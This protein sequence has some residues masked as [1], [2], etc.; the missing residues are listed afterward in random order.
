[1]AIKQ[2]IS[3]ENPLCGGN[4]YKDILNLATGIATRNIKQLVFTGQEDWTLASINSHGIANFRYP[5]TISDRLA[6]TGNIVSSHFVSNSSGNADA[7]TESV[8]I[9]TQNILYL[10]RYESDIS[11]ADALK[12][13]LSDQYTAGTPVIVWYVLA[14]PTT[15]TITLPHG[16]SGTVEGY[17]TQDGTPTPSAPIYPT[18]N[19]INAFINKKYML[20]ETAT[21]TLTSLPAEIITDGQPIGANLLDKDN[22]VDG[23]AF[24]P[25]TGSNKMVASNNTA[26]LLLP[27]K[28][29][30]TYTI[31]RQNI[32]TKRFIM[33]FLTSNEIYADMPI[34][35]DVGSSD[36]LILTSTSTAES[37]YLCFYYGK[38]GGSDSSTPEEIQAQLA[39]VM[40]NEGSTPLPYQPYAPAVIKGNMQQSGTPTPT[41]P[42]TPSECGDRTENLWDETY[43]NIGDT[44]TNYYLS[45]YVGDGEFTLSTTLPQ[46]DIGYNYTNIFLMAGQQTTGANNSRDGAWFGHNKTVT[47]V[48]GYVTI[49]YRNYSANPSYDGDP[50]H[51]HTMLNAG[52]T[53]KPFEP[54]GYKNTIVSGGVTTPV[55]LGKVQSTRVIKKLVLTGSEADW[56]ITGTGRLALVIPDL[57]LNETVCVC[58]HYKG[59]FKTSYSEINDGECTIER[60]RSE[61]AVYD[62]NYTD[63][64]SY[65]QY[66]ADQY[67]NG[68]PVTIWYVL[69]VPTT[70]IVNEPIRKIGDYSDSVSVANIP[71]T[72]GGQTF[73]VSTTLKPSEVDL[74]YHGW[75]EHEAEKYSRTENLWNEEYIGISSSGTITYSSVYVGSGNFTLSTTARKTESTNPSQNGNANIFFL[76]GNVSSGASTN[77]NGVWNEQ[78]RTV[79]ATDGYVTIAYRYLEG[80]S[81]SDPRNN[82]TMLNAGSTALPYEPYWKVNE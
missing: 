82:D 15:E 33:C 26:I 18:A 8:R 47:A 46:F 23:G 27:C 13:W 16:L 74:T 41:S 53:A 28:P 10:R 65:K 12:Q 34:Y 48:D 2:F 78:N 3:L 50:R 77:G 5:G 42:I 81:G 7:T 9:T 52:S 36:A 76:T 25:N 61:W 80:D 24:Y 63:V 19:Y 79:T 72:S 59:I 66:L 70:G 75:H 56:R 43:P 17:L 14:T 49:V 71:T 1:M 55:Y 22:I 21:D 4:V 38:T 67:S 54:Y 32:I 64:N 45:L 6:T 11:T 44:S 40:I 37:Q 57:P 69:T 51:Y 31:S 39:E 29:N 58:S 30:T 20:Y 68:T 73:D 35:G 62:S 60:S